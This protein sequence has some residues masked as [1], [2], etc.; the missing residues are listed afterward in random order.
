MLK[1]SM[2]RSLPFSRDSWVSAVLQGSVGKKLLARD[3]LG[4]GLYLDP[5]WLSRI[6]RSCVH[7]P[8][9]P[10]S[11]SQPMQSALL[12]PGVAVGFDC[13]SEDFMVL[14]PTSI[15]LKWIPFLASLSAICLM[16][17]TSSPPGVAGTKMGV[18]CPLLVAHVFFFFFLS[19]LLSSFLQVLGLYRG[20]FPSSSSFNFF[21]CMPKAFFSMAFL[22][23]S[24]YPA[25]FILIM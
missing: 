5:K 12:Q 2:G 25:Y 4:R 24:V 8:P 6:L 15:M 23:F 21:S 22:Y 16:F 14:P 7:S 19:L 11:P 3:L 17:L 10:L 9:P 20:L 18:M 13:W 1:W